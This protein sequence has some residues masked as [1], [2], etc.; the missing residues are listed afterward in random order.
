MNTL[1]YLP[2][3]PGQYTLYSVAADDVDVSSVLCPVRVYAVHVS[4]GGLC[5]VY[6]VRM[7]V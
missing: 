5:T 1:L 2:V 6:C 3:T 4:V 7:N